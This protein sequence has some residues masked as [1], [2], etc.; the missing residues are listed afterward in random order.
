MSYNP[1]E[2]R[3]TLR[4]L[5]QNGLSFSIDG[6]LAT[7][8]AINWV[9]LRMYGF[10]DYPW[11]EVWN[12]FDPFL[13]HLMETPDLFEIWYHSNTKEEQPHV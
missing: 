5:P 2:A 3:R 13:H 7:P 12:L 10:V 8:H 11:I 4:R 1:A 6:W 9:T